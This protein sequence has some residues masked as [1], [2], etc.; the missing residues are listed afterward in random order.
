MSIFARGH[1]SIATITFIFI[2]GRLPEATAFRLC[3]R[4]MRAENRLNSTSLTA[5]GRV[6][7]LLATRIEI[8][9]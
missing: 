8:A 5:Q 2:A 7:L 9:Q 3:R 1:R 4:I 6:K